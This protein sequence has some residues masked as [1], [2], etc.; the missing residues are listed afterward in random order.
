V[1]DNFRRTSKSVHTVSSDRPRFK[2]VSVQKYTS[3]TEYRRSRY[4]Y[5]IPN[6]ILRLV[7]LRV[8]QEKNTKKSH[9]TAIDKKFLSPG[10]YES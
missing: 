10:L 3:S 9:G 5:F 8:H 7:H 1:I 2:I 4:L 6:L